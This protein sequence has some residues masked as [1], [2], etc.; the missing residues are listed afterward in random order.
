MGGYTCEHDYGPQFRLEKNSQSVWSQTIRFGV[1][2]TLFVNPGA[3]EPTN[4]M[5]GLGL[6]RIRFPRAG[7][8]DLTLAMISQCGSP[9]DEIDEMAKKFSFG[10]TQLN[11]ST[12][13][14]FLGPRHFLDP[15]GVGIRKNLDEPRMNPGAWGYFP[16]IQGGRMGPSGPSA[17]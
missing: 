13:C 2:P 17:S 1:D 5:A 8:N 10:L 6:F 3:L 11:T 12:K 15:L 16:L 7:S 9:L 14:R 4:F